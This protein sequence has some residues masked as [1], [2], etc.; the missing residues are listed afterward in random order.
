VNH[1]EAPIKASKAKRHREPVAKVRLK[2]L[3]GGKQRKQKEVLPMK[4]KR[5]LIVACA[6]LFLVVFSMGDLIS[7]ETAQPAKQKAATGKTVKASVPNMIETFLGT[8][9]GV[10]L[11]K[12]TLT[13][14]A[15]YAAEYHFGSGSMREREFVLDED[16][17]TF[18][19][20]GARFAGCDPQG[21]AKAEDLKTGDHVRVAFDRKDD[22]YIA[23]I[24]LRIEKR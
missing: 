8:V 5:F 19:I 12:K 18:D 11:E 17:I 4:M 15:R 10:D 9:T 22:N 6:V 14:S 1:P 24:V 16:D 21:C 13:V 3:T 7:A 20:S 2:T 23:N